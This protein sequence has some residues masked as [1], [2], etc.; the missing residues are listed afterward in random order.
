ME[1]LRL[2]L[3]NLAVASQVAC[4]AGSSPVT[5]V[6]FSEGFQNFIQESGYKGGAAGV[7]FGERLGFTIGYGHAYPGYSIHATTLLPLSSISKSITAVAVLKLAENGKLDLSSKV[8]GRHGIINSIAP[9]KDT[10]DPRLYEMT[11]DDLL[12]HAGGWD[13]QVGLV[14]DP[15]FN[16]VLVK[17]SSQMPNITKELNSSA[18]LNPYDIIKFMMSVPLDFNP[19][20]KSV[21]SNFGY[22]VLGRIIEEV[23]S[24]T[25][26]DYIHHQI[27]TPCGMWHTKLGPRNGMEF[28]S[29]PVE[30]ATK[31]ANTNHES[32][33]QYYAYNYPYLVDS[34]LGWFSNVYDVMRFVHCLDGSSG[35]SLL[36]AT[37]IDKLLTKPRAGPQH[38]ESWQGAGFMVH[39]SGSVWVEADSFSSDVILVHQNLLHNKDKKSSSSGNE[40]T[41][42]VYLLDG[43]SHNVTPLKQLSKAMIDAEENWPIDNFYVDDVVDNI[44]TSG[45]VTRITRYMLEEHRANPYLQALHHLKYDVRWL[46]AYTHD[47][48]TYM[49]VIAEEN[50]SGTR[51]SIAKTGLSEEKLIQTKLHLENY[52]YNMTFL[53]NYKSYSHQD[54][55][56]FLA[57]FR[58]GAIKN[59]THI[60]Y[61]LRHYDR[62]YNTLL[63]L[64]EERGYHPLVQSLEYRRNDALISFI[65]EEDTGERKSEY[66]SY[67][68]ISETNLEKLVQLNAVQQKKLVYLDSTDKHGKPRFSA[69]FKKMG[70]SKWL[71]NIALTEQD[72]DETITRKQ[73]EGLLPTIIVGYTDRQRK[74]QFTLCME[75][76]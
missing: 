40:P 2:F 33:T 41:A 52:G 27:L 8:F 20:T 43:K 57:I 9:H 3:L 69:V 35:Y 68:D 29:K 66:K 64:Y 38:V 76:M 51:L 19:G 49:T 16:E 58:I 12:H 60:R 1:K 61:G 50:P 17:Q 28:N 32:I 10:V 46:N 26:E 36:N 70:L 37:M 56:T 25:Y 74:L 34:A 63:N 7:L 30:D 11:V 6:K 71:F 62:P 42:W 13:A 72:L 65:F 67:E 5:D 53:Q 48:K 73:R 45:K 18:P 22:S 75:K 55:Y 15:L 59:T 44:V 47:K 4:S 31:D 39:Y 14:S 21:P 23:S 24:S 54:H